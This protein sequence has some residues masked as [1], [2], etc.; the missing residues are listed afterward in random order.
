V[1][2][3]T[4]TKADRCVHAG[5]HF[6]II[7]DAYP[8]SPGHCLIVSNREVSDFFELSEDEHADLASMV[9]VAK[10]LIEAEHAPSGYNIGMNC[11]ISAGQ[12]VMHFHCH[13]IPRYTGD[14]E[15][16]RGGVRHCVPGKGYY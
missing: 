8:V 14:A 7:R 4:N 16:P 15:D 3:F 9:L 2:A 11:G 12:T 10:Q 1:S 13:V 6:F 5:R